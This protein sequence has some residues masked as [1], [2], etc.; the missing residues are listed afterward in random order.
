MS[1]AIQ[2]L[3]CI[4]T[5]ESHYQAP[6]MQPHD[7]IKPSTLTEEAHIIEAE[8]SFPS[9]QLPFPREQLLRG[10]LSRI[11]SPPAHPDSFS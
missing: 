6:Q 11:S 4:A 9:K 5:L 10:L 3:F 1:G 8:N 7:T 2:G